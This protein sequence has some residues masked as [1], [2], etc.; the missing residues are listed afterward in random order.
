MLLP[1]KKM[2]TYKTLLYEIARKKIECENW[3]T[4]RTIIFRPK[5]YKFQ[6]KLYCIVP[7][8]KDST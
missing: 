6:N 2:Q 4:I 1:F 3:P 8:C 7:N 5:D